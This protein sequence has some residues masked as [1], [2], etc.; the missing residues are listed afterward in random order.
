MINWWC[1]WSSTVAKIMYFTIDAL[2][3]LTLSISWSMCFG[4]LF[5]VSIIS[6]IHFTLNIESDNL[7]WRRCGLFSSVL[8]RPLSSEYRIYYKCLFARVM[9]YSFCNTSVY[10]WTHFISINITGSV[11][12]SPIVFLLFK[13]RWNILI[14]VYQ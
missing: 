9:S 1:I 8:H 2:L 13:E 6:F 14:D 3:W 7:I 11:Q 10:G 12:I 5:A 4:I